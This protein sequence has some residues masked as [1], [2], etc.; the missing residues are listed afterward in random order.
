M[1]ALSSHGP[2]LPEIRSKYNDI[3]MLTRIAMYQMCPSIHWL[4][5]LLG[6]ITIELAVANPE[7]PVH[8]TAEWSIP[9]VGAP[10]SMYKKDGTT[11]TWKEIPLG[12]GSPTIMF[13][14]HRIIPT[15]SHTPLSSP[16]PRQF[17]FLLL[18]SLHC[19]S[20]YMSSA[21][22]LPPLFAFVGLDYVFADLVIQ[23]PH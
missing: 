12:L 10:S 20:I 8:C 13:V 17:I 4:Y 19:L 23:L 18:L 9:G 2:G 16:S 1:Q 6:D 7:C 11:H 22:F 5:L 3:V 14:C 15:L 21:A